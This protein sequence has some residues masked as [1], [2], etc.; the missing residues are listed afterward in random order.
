MENKY[1]VSE[2]TIKENER[3]KHIIEKENNRWILK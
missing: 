2:I 1:K 3:F